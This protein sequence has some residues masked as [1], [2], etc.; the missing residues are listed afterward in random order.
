LLETYNRLPITD[1]NEKG[2]H[3]VEKRDPGSLSVA[4]KTGFRWK[5]PYYR[6]F[7]RQ[8]GKR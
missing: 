5:I 1:E 7:H 4:E 8:H 2:C 3:P 6:D